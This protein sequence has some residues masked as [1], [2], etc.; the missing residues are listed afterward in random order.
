MRFESVYLVPHVFPLTLSFYP[1]PGKVNKDQ[2]HSTTRI[3]VKT[4]PPS[5]RYS[6]YRPLLIDSRIH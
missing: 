5:E 1:V 4:T 6:E 3:T 2:L